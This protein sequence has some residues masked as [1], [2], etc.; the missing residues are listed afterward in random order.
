M[1]VGSEAV[2]A[3]SHQVGLAERV[4]QSLMLAADHLLRGEVEV[5]RVADLTFPQYNVLRI[6]RGARPE[7]LSCGTIAQ[8]MLNRDSDM[9]RLLDKL[10]QR[11][12]VKRIRDARDR[13]MVTATI[14]DAGLQLLRK[15]DGP[16][17][18]VHRTQLEHMTP[19]QLET[20]LALAEE[21]RRA[22][23]GMG[24]RG[25]AIAKQ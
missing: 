15:L 20:L 13:R 18:R 5:L 10:E 3:R 25:S 2:R 22:R 9:T 11:R 6:L 24:D 23:P 21:V 8:R 19:K 16:V 17:D 12:L 14:T 1:V 4:F 7:A